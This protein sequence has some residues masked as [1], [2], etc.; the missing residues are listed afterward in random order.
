MTLMILVV[1][2]AVIIVVVQVVGL[3]H[4]SGM[5]NNV[6]VYDGC[7]IIPHNKTNDGDGDKDL[8][9]MMSV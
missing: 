1:L 4:S 6:G 7:R 3:F 2:L 9:S 5:M 8:V